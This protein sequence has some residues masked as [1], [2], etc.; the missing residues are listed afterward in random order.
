[1][2]GWSEELG[3]VTSVTGAETLSSR[4]A[5]TAEQGPRTLGVNTNFSR[6]ESTTVAFVLLSAPARAHN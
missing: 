1:M 5:N 3:P 2:A 4:D 6:L